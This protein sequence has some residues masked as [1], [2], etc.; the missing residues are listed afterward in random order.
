MNL[1]RTLLLPNFLKF[2][3]Y[4]LRNRVIFVL[5]SKTSQK[6]GVNIYLDFELV[7]GRS[8]KIAAIMTC[9]LTSD[10]SQIAVTEHWHLIKE[11]TRT[12]VTARRV[13]QSIIHCHQLSPVFSTIIQISIQI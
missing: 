6:Q 8:E 13:Y 5:S 10:I 1:R 2:A 9:F 11:G 3:S 12:M 7:S 4:D